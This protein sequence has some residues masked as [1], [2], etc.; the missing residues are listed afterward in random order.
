[1]ILIAVL[2]ASS[3]DLIAVIDVIC[4]SNLSFI[5]GIRVRSLVCTSPSKMP[6]STQLESLTTSGDVS[7]SYLD[8]G[9]V[10]GNTY[11][12]LVFVHGMGFN[13]GAVTLVLH[14]VLLTLFLMQVFSGSFCLSLLCAIS[15]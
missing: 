5:R 9:E 8:S 3:V 4:S 6:I 2:L 13:G 1:M 14:K 15:A 7:Y 11:T 12:T 10:P